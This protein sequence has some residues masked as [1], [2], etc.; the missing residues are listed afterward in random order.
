[1]EQE[2]KLRHNQQNKKY[3]DKN[4]DK[5]NMHKLEKNI[6]VKCGSTYTN[7]HKSRHERSMKCILFK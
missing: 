7:C 4:K 1:M 6:C 2:K 5:I 3:R